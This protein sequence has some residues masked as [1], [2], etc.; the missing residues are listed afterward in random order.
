[1]L[2]DLC[3]LSDLRTESDVEQKL[4]WHLLTLSYPAGFGL[5]SPDFVTKLS[6][7]R[8]EIGKGASRKL[9]YPDYVV[10]LAG[11]PLLV[12][13]AK[14]PSESVEQGLNE[15]RLYGN[16]MNALFGESINPCFRVI[17][18]NGAELWSS[19]IDTATPDL[20]LK[21]EELVPTHPEFAK[22]VDFCGK[23]SLQEK[24]DNLR[25]RFRKSSYQ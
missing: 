23:R 5:S 13:E 3:D 16:E 7:R 4:L 18:C 17:S 21:F 25:R 9:Y 14:S 8:H 19:P 11:L 10:S 20:R 12:I 6:I 24:A 2:P 15:A 22:L 1:M